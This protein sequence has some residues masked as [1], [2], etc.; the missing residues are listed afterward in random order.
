[1]GSPSDIHPQEVLAAEIYSY[2]AVIGS[3]DSVQ[4]S[5]FPYGQ[6]IVKLPYD[7]EKYFP[8]RAAEGLRKRKNVQALKIGSVALGE[9]KDWKG[10]WKQQ[11]GFELLEVELPLRTAEVTEE[12]WT[13]DELWMQCSHEYSPEPPS[14]FPIQVL[15]QVLDRFAIPPLWLAG[16]G[17]KQK[18]IWAKL[19]KV[20]STLVGDNILSFEFQITANLPSM[21]G[22][23]DLVVRL[24][25]F[26]IAWP[27]IPFGDELLFYQWN[28]EQWN[29]E[30][31]DPE[32]RDFIVLNWDYDPERQEILLKDIPMPPRPRQKN[33]NPLTIYQAS[34]RLDLLATGKLLEE[35]S[36]SGTAIVRVDDTLL[37]GRDVAWMQA[38]G[39]RVDKTRMGPT[40]EASNTQ[41]TKQ[42]SL[43][44]E[45]NAFLSERF[46]EK[47]SFIFRHW[48][49]PGVTRQGA[50]ENDVIAILLDMEFS[51]ERPDPEEPDPEEPRPGEGKIVRKRTVL[52]PGQEPTDLYI[53]IELTEEVTTSTTREKKGEEAETYR[54]QISTQVLAINFYAQMDGD[55][56]R[57]ARDAETLMRRLKKQFA[58][59]ADLR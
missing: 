27:G 53:W 55:G 31:W 46:N 35:D 42:T 3:N 5:G 17:Y 7:G 28:P 47:R 14:Y 24:E 19:A 50:R 56:A 18:Y 40:R 21:L 29:P 57:L 8:M 52:R 41:V 23:Q 9:P 37:S 13:A 15:F 33:G 16:K 43:I 4:A 26:R 25:T 6:I 11:T 51:S 39:E 45:F 12:Q 2:K 1:M 34:I 22:D 10:D 58:A 20:G 54:T 30:Q 49:F 48:V 36:L 38:S 44:S 32:K 59:V